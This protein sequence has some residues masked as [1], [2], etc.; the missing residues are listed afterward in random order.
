MQTKEL[1]LQLVRIGERARAG[2]ERR[3]VFGLLAVAAVLFLFPLARK[4]D[5][6][7]GGPESL[8]ATWHYPVISNVMERLRDGELPLW[9]ANLSMGYPIWPVEGALFLHPF[10]WMLAWLPVTSFL[11]L[12]VLA[13]MLGALAAFYFVALSRGVNRLPAVIGAMLYVWNSFHIAHFYHGDYDVAFSAMVLPLI[14]HSHSRWTGSGSALHGFLACLLFACVSLISGLAAWFHVVAA[15]WGVFLVGRRLGMPNIPIRQFAFRFGV[16]VLPSVVFSA[17]IALPRLEWISQ[18]VAAPVLGSRPWFLPFSA[19]PALV[20]P[21]FFGGGSGF[22]YWNSGEP[23]EVF[24]YPGV[25][26]LLP[27]VAWPLMS[28]ASRNVMRLAV[29]GGAVAFIVASSGNV[30]PLGYLADAVPALSEMLKPARV[31]QVAV[32]CAAWATMLGFGEAI[33]HWREVRGRAIRV[34][35][36]AT[37]GYLLLLLLLFIKPLWSSAFAAVYPNS[38]IHGIAAAGYRSEL[39]DDWTYGTPEEMWSD[40][41]KQTRNNAMQR[42]F[43]QIIVCGL[44]TGICAGLMTSRRTPVLWMFTVVALLDLRLAA[45]SLQDSCSTT[46]NRLP[47]V[48]RDNL[49]PLDETRIALPY[50]LLLRNSLLLQGKALAVGDVS[51]PLGNVTSAFR[52]NPLLEP[53]AATR[54]Q[55]VSYVQ[56][57]AA[58][59]I[60]YLSLPTDAGPRLGRYPLKLVASDRDTSVVQ[61]ENVMPR[62]WIVGKVDT[63]PSREAAIAR[64]VLQPFQY[65]A[66][67]VSSQAPTAIGIARSS[68]EPL[69]ART[70]FT[71]RTPTRIAWRGSSAEC[72]V[73]VVADPW[74]PGWKAEVNHVPSKVMELNGWMRGIEVP[75]GSSF[76]EMRFDPFSVRLGVFVSL[77]W[78]CGF[79]TLAVLQIFRHLLPRYHQ[80]SS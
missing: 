37:A 57:L 9:N 40:L 68:S 15:V 18:S 52:L 22:A 24:F 66:V 23:A 42:C 7:P 17:A 71:E 54:M 44:V 75:E 43:Q 4:Q 28:S 64:T 49:N 51:R 65:G 35:G 80:S 70:E 47:R 76:A 12:M 58:A 79:I 56:Q 46:S 60:G 55:P 5:E 59:N 30:F 11:R 38:R 61:V 10:S 62:L 25:F 41:K 78:F 50:H 33:D 13:H 14:L 45:S 21:R 69:F 48:L 53:S 74:Y 26:L 1:E 67:A 3:L 6:L 31:V 2:R 34:F 19:I 8:N 63:V 16:A 39:Y 36:G 73:A 29:V 72:G 32:F 27:V 20:V 77:G